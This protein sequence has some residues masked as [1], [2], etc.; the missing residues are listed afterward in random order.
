MSLVWVKCGSL[1]ASTSAFYTM[2]Y[3]Q[4][5]IL[6][7]PWNDNK[8]QKPT[9]KA[10]LNSQNRHDKVLEL[11]AATAKLL[12]C[13]GGIFRH[14]RISLY[15]KPNIK[16]FT[17]TIQHFS[18]VNYMLRAH[19]WMI[20][21]TKWLSTVCNVGGVRGRSLGRGQHPLPSKEEIVLYVLY[22]VQHYPS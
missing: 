11:S 19:A 20:T 7:H 3:P 21:A 8:Q 22:G 13:H 15:H 12:H 18:C 14:H 1:P 5:R 9:N 4:I 17:D 16:G 2:E 6:P 10:C